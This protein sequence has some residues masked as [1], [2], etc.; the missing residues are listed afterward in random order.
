M[1]SSRH[2]ATAYRRGPPHLVSIHRHHPLLLPD[3]TYPVN[4]DVLIY[5]MCSCVQLQCSVCWIR[6]LWW[7]DSE[8]WSRWTTSCCMQDTWTLYTPLT[9]EYTESKKDGSTVICLQP[10]FEEKHLSALLK[11]TNPSAC[12]NFCPRRSLLSLILKVPDSAA[13]WWRYMEKPKHLNCRRKYCWAVSAG[14]KHSVVLQS[15][16]DLSD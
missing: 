11:A 3:V 13:C 4:N 8:S 12:S 10:L 2:V 15:F 7:T 1:N 5:C 9:C 6:I 16:V 14:A